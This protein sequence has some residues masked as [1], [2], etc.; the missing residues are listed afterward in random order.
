MRKIEKNIGLG[1]RIK[2]IRL[3]LGK[4]QSEFGEMFDPPAPK[5]A[6]S[7][8]EHGGGPNK[9]RLK[10]IAELGGVS[11]EYLINGSQLSITDTRKLLD[12]AEDNTKLSDSEL[13][14]LR[15]SQLDFQA[16]TNRIAENS[17]REIRQSINHQRKLISENP[18]SILSGYGLSDFLVTFNLV[19][20]H[21]SKE[22]QEIFMVLLN[23]FRQIATGYI[24]YDKSDLLPNIDKLLSSFTVKKD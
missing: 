7:R 1:Q 21:G 5:G 23:M 2:S 20:L 8:W 19:R 18:L 4:N 22:Q 12:K 16:N 14:K 6:V 15:E 11:V 13:Q 10:K 24:E 9:R 3:R 17:S